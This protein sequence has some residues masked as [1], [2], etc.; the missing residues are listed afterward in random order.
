MSNS[1]L[2]EP[3]PP[4]G[5]EAAP[6]RPDAAPGSAPLSSDQE[7]PTDPE[8]PSAL[9]PAAPGPEAG[10]P[11]SASSDSSGLA[12]SDDA[13]AP[14]SGVRR[15]LLQAGERVNLHGGNGRRHSIRLA[16]GQVFHT[17]KGGVPHDALIGQPEGVVVASAAG[18]PYIALRPVLEEYTVS[19]PRGATVVYPKDASHILMF[20]DIFP[21][22]RVLEAGAGSGGLSLSLLRA[23]GPAGR[24]YSY[25]RRADFAQT[26]CRNVEA[27]FGGPH[28]A[29][30][31]RL[32]DLVESIGPEPVDRAVLD[33]L[34]PW[35]CVDAVH[36][37]LVP[38]GFL[39]CYV[40]TT[41]QLGRTMETLR[42]HGGWTEP[43]A[44]E[45]NV[46]AWQ[47]EGLAIRP[48]HAGRGHTGFIILARRL[49]DGVQAPLKRRRPAPGAY[50]P[51]YDGPRPRGVERPD[52]ETT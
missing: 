19:M 36:S 8:S 28:P 1:P 21:G 40:A 31:L 50:G 15:G 52:A 46:R 3:S 7:A 16:P 5:L 18:L 42:A 39:C 29:W 34:A 2:S 4:S 22:A 32:G 10:P 43:T 51:D 20:A 17:T 9:E 14:Y 49:A 45:V 38:G 33:L 24:L 35:E 25:E 11:D 41:T 48:G 12:F 23:V 13:P 44:V 27:F 47:A 26:A 6:T 37:R 30:R